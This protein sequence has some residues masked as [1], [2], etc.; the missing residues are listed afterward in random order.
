MKLMFFLPCPSHSQVVHLQLQSCCRVFKPSRETRHMLLVGPYDSSR[1]DSAWHTPPKNSNGLSKKPTS[2]YV[3]WKFLWRRPY[4]QA[5]LG[6][7]RECTVIKRVEVSFWWLIISKIIL[8]S[9]KLIS[10]CIFCLLHLT[11]YLVEEGFSR[12]NSVHPL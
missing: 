10:S 2:R 4:H 6:Q 11:L 8:G 1:A 12:I 5:L 3:M 7:Y 9:E